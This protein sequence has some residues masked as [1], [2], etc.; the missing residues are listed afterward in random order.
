M[1]K[2]YSVR[3]PYAAFVAGALVGT[4]G[5]LIG[6]GGAEFRLP[7]LITLFAL[8]AHRAVRFNLL[9][10][11]ITL[12]VAAV[13]RLRLQLAGDIASYA[14]VLLSM[15]AG[16]MLAAWIGAGALQRIPANRLMKIIA[17]L[18]LLISLMLLIEATALGPA[19][20]ALPAST[21]LRSAVGL[22]AGLTVGA[23][24]SLLG[25]AGGEFIIPILIFVFGA[26]IKIAGSLS[27]LISLPVV[28]VGVLKHRRTGHYRS[29]DVLQYLV[30][31]M[32]LGSVL[33]AAVGGL[34]ASAV[35]TNALKLLLAVVLASSAI[36]LS[37]H[38]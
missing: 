35:P 5:G 2:A 29:R 36:K 24:S 1:S 38:K 30:L 21:I 6:L 13:T 33:G 32:G 22:L 7:L 19:F 27:L 17:A 8:Y 23:V 9:V 10:S 28:A 34:A 14:D 37:N 18:L 25:V 4:L 15:I 26:D 12:A 31:P 11:L 20:P 16:G 3:R